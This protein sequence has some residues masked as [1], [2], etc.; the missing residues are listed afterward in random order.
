[1]NTRPGEEQF[2]RWIDG[3]LDAG[4]EAF[5]REWA[6]SA[7]E[8]FAEWERM[9]D[10]RRDLLRVLQAEEEPPASEFFNARIRAGI[11]GSS[12]R[13]S[14]RGRPWRGLWLP[15]AASVAVV[16]S[17]FAGRAMR[18]AAATPAMLA[19]AGGQSGGTD[20]L[21]PVVYVPEVGVSADWME[22]EDAGAVVIVL[23]GLD[24][25]PDNVELRRTAMRE[26]RRE[27]DSMAGGSVESGSVREVRR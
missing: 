26:Q 4:G 23:E 17:F 1:M 6:R 12:G 21:E 2:A 3:T 22:S 8:E 19:A 9:R 7:P 16:A 25:I 13:A 11:S 5:V 24:A 27:S 10:C 14:G 15:V 18:P 20:E